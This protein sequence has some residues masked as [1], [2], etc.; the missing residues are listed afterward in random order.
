MDRKRLMEDLCFG[1]Y[2][3]VVPQCEFDKV[4]RT[5]DPR[6]EQ[7]LRLRYSGMTYRE[8]GKIMTWKKKPYRHISRGRAEQIVKKALRKL[9]HRARSKFLLARY[10][11]SKDKIKILKAVGFKYYRG[12]GWFFYVTDAYQDMYIGKNYREVWVRFKDR[13]PIKNRVKKYSETNRSANNQAD[14]GRA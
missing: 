8:M 3:E 4:L 9:R 11:L 1:W 13:A 10:V 7:A 12:R 5:I 2:D 14:P 6:E